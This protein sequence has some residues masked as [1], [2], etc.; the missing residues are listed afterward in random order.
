VR[1]AIVGAATSLAI[2][3]KATSFDP[4][5]ITSAREAWSTYQLGRPPSYSLSRA[6]TLGAMA[7]AGGVFGAVYGITSRLVPLPPLLT[8]AFC[9]GG[10]WCA[11][12]LLYRNMADRQLRWS[13]PPKSR[14]PS[15]VAFGVLTAATSELLRRW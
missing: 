11:S 4:S 5:R 10:L 15:L 1:S 14:V 7:A 13:A 6:G 8:G 3:Y 9:G 2:A 12:E